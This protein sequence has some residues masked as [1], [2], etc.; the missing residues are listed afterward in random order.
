MRRGE[1]D[2]QWNTFLSGYGFTIV[3]YLWNFGDGTIDSTSGP[4]VS[5]TFTTI[6]EHLVDLF[7]FDDNNCAA[8]NLVTVP[9][10]VGTTPTFTGTTTSQVLCTGASMCLDGQ[11]NSVTYTGQP[12]NIT[13][14]S[15]Y[16]PDDVG[17]C[18]SSEL[19]VNL[20]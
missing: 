3:K 7:I 16:I 4:V 6:G 18:F 5:H 20:F 9:V 11:V 12:L 19:N 14:D 13:G 8:S 10:W 15:L 2:I 17:F 1:F